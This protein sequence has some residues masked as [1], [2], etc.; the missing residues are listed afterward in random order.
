LIV[1]VHFNGREFVAFHKSNGERI[2][3]RS[4]LNVISFEQFPGVNGVFEINVDTTGRSVI[5]EPL[6]INIGI[7]DTDNGI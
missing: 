2:T 3:D 1:E 5:I 7:Q 4:I 6:T